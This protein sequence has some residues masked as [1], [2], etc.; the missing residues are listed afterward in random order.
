MADGSSGNGAVVQPGKNVFSK[1][2]ADMSS[3]A[4][5]RMGGQQ[6]NLHGS[7]FL[8]DNWV[9]GFAISPNDSIKQNDAY[10]FNYDKLDG[11]LIFTKDQKMLFF[12]G[13]TGN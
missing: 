5:D 13:K 9:H 1:D 11:N 4:S 7:K 8:F 2:V 3:V 12:S 10:L 6:E